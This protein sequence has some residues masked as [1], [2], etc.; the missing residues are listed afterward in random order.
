MFLSTNAR[1]YRERSVVGDSLA[2]QN[3][4][5]R[6]TVQHPEQENVEPALGGVAPHV[7]KPCSVG[8]GSRFFVGVF[9]YDLQPCW[10]QNW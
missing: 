5:A 1:R 7:L 2:F 8:L 4:L 6:E 10:S 9:S 3:A